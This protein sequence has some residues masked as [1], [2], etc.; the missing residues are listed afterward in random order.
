MLIEQ[1]TDLE[2]VRTE[3]LKFGTD[4]RN[5]VKDGWSVTQ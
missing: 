3:S 1:L 2:K 5:R 4:L